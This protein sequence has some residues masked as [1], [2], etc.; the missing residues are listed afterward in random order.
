MGNLERTI[1]LQ[2]GIKPERPPHVVLRGAGS[3]TFD[4][5]VG[6]KTP[7]VRTPMDIN[8]YRFEIISVSNYRMNG[9]KWDKARVLN[10]GFEDGKFIKV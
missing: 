7:D 2:E 4:V 1:S 8:G 5:D 10:K 3:T 9:G 6:A